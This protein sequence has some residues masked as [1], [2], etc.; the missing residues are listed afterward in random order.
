MKTFKSI[1]ASILFLVGAGLVGIGNIV[2]DM[3]G[4]FDAIGLG[5]TVAGDILI[6]YSIIRGIMFI[7]NFIKN[8]TKDNMND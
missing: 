6:F 4:I 1:N 5:I 3:D 7:V 8:K 2:A